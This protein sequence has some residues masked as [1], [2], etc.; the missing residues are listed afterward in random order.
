MRRRLLALALLSTTA[1]LSLAWTAAAVKSFALGKTGTL[2]VTM[3]EGWN[4]ATDG[5][6][7]VTVTLKAPTAKKVSVQATPMPQA[8]PSDAQMK[9][10][11]TT[12]GSYYLPN[13]VE[14]K[15]TLE[16]LN[17]PQVKGFVSSF[18]DASP[19]TE[20]RYVT[21]GCVVSNKVVFTVTL[22]Y[23]DK[24]STDKAAALEAVKSFAVTTTEAPS[25]PTPV[26]SESIKLKSLDGQWVLNIPGAWRVLTE[27]KSRDGK[28]V[29][30]TA[31]GNSGWNLSAFIEP[32]ADPKGDSK[33]ARAFYLERMKNNPMGMDNL[34]EA[35]AGE[36]ATLEYDQGLARF[37]QH[38]L[39]AYVA[40]G[41][42][43]VDVHVSKTDFNEEKDRAVLNALIEGLRVTDE[44]SSPTPT[45]KKP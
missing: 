17:G 30:M 14:K 2:Q 16:E 28:T 3:P 9:E 25:K 20:F 39:N 41:G 43:W 27:S 13:A 7:P 11:A 29:Q 44:K 40:H 6:S 8:N 10:L 26:T 36:V 5:Q 42:M 23:D 35:L 24:N 38:H 37:S 33:A 19:T 4:G 45:L 22:L 15:V 34:K 18:T 1:V 32:A 31:M 21:A 12:I